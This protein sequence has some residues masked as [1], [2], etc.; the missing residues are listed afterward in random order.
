[1]SANFSRRRALASLGAWA[2][3]SPLGSA[4]EE[5]QRR[6]LEPAGRI[7][8]RPELV[9]VLEFEGMAQRKL[10]STVYSTIADGDRRVF[11]R[12]IFRPRM[13]VDTMKLDRRS[14]CLGRSC[15][16]RFWSGRR[17]S[18]SASIPRQNSLPSRGGRPAASWPATGRVF[19]SGRSPPNPRARSGIRSI[20]SAKWNRAGARAAGGEGW[21]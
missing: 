9:N 6:N 11:D 20:R 7:A 3:A 8:P 13:L 5:A 17:R 18:S 16:R 2:A 4:Q 12:M 19:R 21:L 14:G 10:G 1:M 15:S